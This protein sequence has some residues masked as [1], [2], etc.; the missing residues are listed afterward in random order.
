MEPD[1]GSDR[2]AVATGRA[3]RKTLGAMAVA[4]VLVAAGVSLALV[5]PFAT[6]ESD[7]PGV[8]G[9]SYPTGIYTVVREDLSSQMQE[10]ATLGYAGSYDVSAPSG[11]SAETVAQDRQT[12]T[13]DQQTLSA[14]ERTEADQANADNQQTAADQG[15]V[16]TDQSILA[17]D[18]GAESGACAGSGASSA[19]CGQDQQKLS[20]DRSALIQAQQ[21]LQSAQSGAALANDQDQATVQS[22]EAKLQ[23]DEGTLA[24]DQAT[25]T[26]P[27]TTYTYL[28]NV[29]EVISEDQPVYSLDDE[30]VPLLYGSVPAYRAFYVGMSDGA[31]V[32]ELT[33]DL[34]ALGYGAG[35][36][37]SDHYSSATAAAVQAWQR[38]L[39]LPATGRILL[40]EV[41]FEPGP[42]RVTTVTPSVGQSVGGGGLNGSGGS[43]GGDSALTATSTTPQ[44]SIALDADQQS[45]VAVGDQVTI[46]LPD[47]ETTSGVISSVGTVATTPSGGGSP[48]ITVLVT[49]ADPAATGDWDQASVTVTITTAAVTNALV[50]PVDALLARTNGSYAVEAVGANGVHRLVAVTLG[51]FDDA[52]GT[53][54]VTRGL[55]A[56]QRVVVPRI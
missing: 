2:M 47:D 30:A 51:I 33:R 32:G 35:L 18:D 15:D 28:P 43:G 34:L 24:S 55:S 23:D 49:P 8:A 26:N 27:G 19:A 14:D 25:E 20:T 37:Q 39:G 38:A 9:I 16:D 10:S 50:V 31:D 21:Q 6:G 45:E 5:D 12:V 1:T 7:T 54:Q 56:G 36:T 42:I 29:G 17:A 11:T 4:L 13:Q 46:S 41:V 44:V 53:V 22:E 40:G 52:N 48:T 3:R